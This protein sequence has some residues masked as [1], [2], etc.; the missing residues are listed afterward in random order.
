MYRRDLSDA[1]KSG[2]DTQSAV[3]DIVTGYTL[4][5]YAKDALKNHVLQLRGTYN[6]SEIHDEHRALVADVWFDAELEA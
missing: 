1:F 5:S 4:T 2:A 3:N 6:V